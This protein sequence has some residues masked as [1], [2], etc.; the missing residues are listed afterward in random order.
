[1]VCPSTYST[2]NIPAGTCPCTVDYN[3]LLT[4]D[5]NSPAGSVWGGMFINGLPTLDFITYCCKKCTNYSP[6]SLNMVCVGGCTDPLALN[7]DATQLIDDGSC[8]YNGCMDILAANYNSQAVF[9]DG[10]CVYAGCTDPQAS[11]YNPIATID[12]GSC[13]CIKCCEFI[14]GLGNVSHTLLSSNTTPCQCFRHLG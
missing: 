12:D 4:I 7:Y 9:D 2:N 8:M 3:T 10:S 11:N 1:M 14:D 6:L 13:Q 5:Y